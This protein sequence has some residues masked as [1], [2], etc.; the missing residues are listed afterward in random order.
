MLIGHSQ[1]ANN[2]IDMARVLEAKNVPVALLIT[3]APFKQD[4]VPGNVARAINYYQSGGWG[5]PITAAAGFKGKLSNIDVKDDATVTH[6]NIDKSDRVRADISRE[7]AA[8]PKPTAERS[9]R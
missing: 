5:D 2:V 4:P 8:I 3:L 6:I 9:Q 7:I 1:G